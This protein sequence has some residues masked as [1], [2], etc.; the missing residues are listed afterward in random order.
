MGIKSYIVSLNIV[1]LRDMVGLITDHS[2]KAKVNTIA[3]GGF[4][5]EC[6]A[7]N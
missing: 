4:A 5:I 6:N 1:I 7:I 2:N 3:V